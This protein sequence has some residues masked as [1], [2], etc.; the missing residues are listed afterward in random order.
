M[1]RKLISSLV[2]I[3]MLVSD[4]SGWGNRSA[5]AMI[6][7][8]EQK[9]II[10]I[11]LRDG[12]DETLLQGESLE[13]ITGPKSHVD[14]ERESSVTGSEKDRGND[15]QLILDLGQGIPSSKMDGQA[16]NLSPSNPTTVSSTLFSPREGT[17]NDMAKGN[18]SSAK[19][20]GEGETTILPDRQVPEEKKETFV[21]N[22]VEKKVQE[23]ANLQHT[24]PSIKEFDEKTP[25]FQPK[26]RVV[27]FAE[28]SQEKKIEKQDNLMKNWELAGGESDEELILKRKSD[29][30]HTDQSDGP[31]FEGDIRVTRSETQQE[32]KEHLLRKKEKTA[33]S[34]RA[35]LSESDD[36]EY[37]SDRG[38]GYSGMENSPL[39]E[40]QRSGVELTNFQNQAF[41]SGAFNPFSMKIGKPTSEKKRPSFPYE[42]H[43]G[44][45]EKRSSYPSQGLNI[46]GGGGSELGNFSEYEGSGLEDFS[47]DSV[48]PSRNLFAEE[49]DLIIPLDQIR[50]LSPEVQD[51]LHHVKVRIIDGKLN[52]K[53]WLGIGGGIVIGAGCA[54]PWMVIMF[55]SLLACYA[56]NVEFRYNNGTNAVDPK[57]LDAHFRDFNSWLNFKSMVV[58]VGFPMGIAVAS[59]TASIFIDLTKDS[60][61]SFS[62]Q[63]STKHSLTLW[64]TKGG[65]Y[66]GAFFAGLLPVY[67]L[68]HSLLGCDLSA[69][70]F[71]QLQPVV[72]YQ[73][74]ISNDIFFN[75]ST[76]YILDDVFPNISTNYLNLIGPGAIACLF[77]SPLPQE[78]FELF[79]IGA[80]FLFF[81]TSLYYGYQVSK[82]LQKWLNDSFFLKKEDISHLN[83]EVIRQDYLVQFKDIIRIIASENINEL[84]PLYNTV[85]RH[86][87]RKIDQEFDSNHEE[88]RGFE[89]LRV[90]KVFL[91]VYHQ[92]KH[93]LE[94]ETTDGWKKTWASR[95]GWAIPLIATYGKMVIY[96]FI[97][98]QFL[99]KFWPSPDHTKDGAYID[100]IQPN[101]GA[102]ALSCIFGYS[103]AH[104][105]HGIVEKKAVE[106]CVYELLGGKKLAGGN[107]HAPL[108]LGLKIWDYLYGIF[109]TLPYL[110][111]GFAP[112]ANELNPEWPNLYQIYPYPVSLSFNVG[113][114]LFILSFGIADIFNNAAAF[115][116]SSSILVNGFD[117]L[118][119]YFYVFEEYKRDK[120]IRITTQLREIFKE[121]KHDVL[122]QVHQ[123]LSENYKSGTN[124][125]KKN[126]LKKNMIKVIE[127][128]DSGTFFFEDQV[129]LK[130]VFKNAENT[131]V[132]SYS[133]HNLS[134]ETQEFLKYIKTQ[135]VKGVLNWQQKAGII[136]GVITGLAVSWPLMAIIFYGLLA[137]YFQTFGA[138]TSPKYFNIGTDSPA[139]ITEG[140]SHFNKVVNIFTLTAFVGFPLG[141]D[142]T[143]RTATILKNLA[144][145]KTS[146]FSIQKTRNHSLLLLGAKGCLYFGTFSAS[147]L[148]VY[149]L[150]DGFFGS[151]KD[152]CPGSN[153]TCS[154]LEGWIACPDDP[155]YSNCPNGTPYCPQGL[156]GFVYTYTVS[157]DIFFNITGIINYDKFCNQTDDFPSKV[158]FWVGAP[159]L[160]V[161]TFLQY[162]Y[163]V[164][165]TVEAWSNNYFFGKMRASF[166]LS[167]LEA[168]RKKYLT[169]F[170]DLK[171]IIYEWDEDRV[172]N[173]YKR[174]FIDEAA[175]LHTDAE[176]NPEKLTTP[177]ALHVLT[178]LENLHNEYKE[179]VEETKDQDWKKTWASRLSWS[180]PLIATYGRMFIFQYILANMLMS[181][182]SFWT[183]KTNFDEDTPSTGASTL[184]CIL[185]GIFANITQGWMEKDA[186]EKGVYDILGGDKIPDGSSHAHLR[187]SIKA[188]DY[189]YGLFNTL[190]YL[191]VGFFAVGYEASIGILPWQVLLLISFGIADA[192]N[193]AVAFHDSNLNVVNAYD[194]LVT[195]YGTP[196]TEQKK[197]RL[198]RMTRQLRRLFKN[199][200]PDVLEEV[201]WELNKN[202][203]NVQDGEYESDFEQGEDEY[204][205]AN[206]KD[207]I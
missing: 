160:F 192:F 193:N 105:T 200:H 126:N 14:S 112:L 90:L 30:I 107:S 108:R 170:K 2:I 32:P 166:L 137:P 68:C 164:S 180:I 7:S 128:M 64:A 174:L 56:R 135:V 28:E 84:S 172:D 23:D 41:L 57:V 38:T 83:L 161:D 155:G 92:H 197:D 186:V 53:Q 133:S 109:Q 110:V 190:P 154:K 206:E 167:S 141:V 205:K 87:L 153:H 71:L 86:N 123:I 3:S 52:W 46:N 111:I 207:E 165:T 162:G 73:Y 187:R 10:P 70:F 203:Q 79:G 120:L 173:A 88:L 131:K 134:F 122:E 202:S 117:A 146:S 39:P 159:F 194:S 82:T 75:I 18:A 145:E 118:V 78:N 61:H 67:Y 94:E 189:L 152:S 171:R 22:R 99:G 106:E 21:L 119:S 49:E 101:I 74:Y 201:D 54:W 12:P 97:I 148:P 199:L 198:I 103:L 35:L 168:I 132:E 13:D 27:L 36:L 195:S 104:V 175:N 115:H 158:V 95:I 77:Q 138:A 116:H 15:R 183:T 125:W 51:F 100:Y 188:W 24:L 44:S 25:L 184:T 151:F 20:S 181:F 136:G 176:E 177:E 26:K 60:N 93:G 81:S 96:Q 62:I 9:Q 204:S 58:L 29:G 178:I 89:S 5:S 185:G 34:F 40:S 124:I 169:Q 149:Y 43:R 42:G 63:K 16:L 147:I 91:D 157:A 85:F 72:N 37:S 6:E 59:K 80:V 45:L 129:T 47:V 121:M 140:L 143:S 48:N 55:D 33:A 65:A 150:Y 114:I 1:F 179:D 76:N 163:Q 196:S 69:Q 182:S 8:D 130:K 66:C 17:G 19:S 50:N 102:I 31:S 156:L 139:N 127:G 191:A 4:L 142:A 113:Q 98:A 144:A 11:Q